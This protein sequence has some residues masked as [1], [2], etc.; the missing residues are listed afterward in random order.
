MTSTALAADRTTTRALSAGLVA[1]P[2]FT[3]LL[4]VQFAVRDGFDITH[5]P[6]SL[7]ALGDA[8][9]IQVFNFVASGL[10]TIAF[11]L[12]V[13]RAIYPGHTATWGPI[14]LAVYGLGLVVAGIFTADPALGFPPGTPDR[15]PDTFTVH[16][17][18][19]AFAP[20]IAFTALIV[21]CLVF[22]RRF[23]SERATAWV[24]YSMATAI[25]A[26]VLVVQVPPDG[27]SLRLAAGA[28]IGWVW[29][30]ALATRLLSARRHAGERRARAALAVSQ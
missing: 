15:I 27:A 6:L 22:A 26:L 18:I 8:G 24:G 1:G 11:A 21:A 3:I 20:P 7:L 4:L 5:H 19:H 23:R 28:V 13:R 25:I 10:L 12:G 30:T 29:V 17:T 16:G 2:L 9:W 14:L